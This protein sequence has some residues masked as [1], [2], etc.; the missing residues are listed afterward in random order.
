MTF[1]YLPVLSKMEELY[2]M[3]LS[4]HRFRAYLHLLQGASKDDMLMP[5]ASYNPMA[6]PHVLEKII[7]LQAMKAEQLMTAT[8]QEL[9]R[10][11]RHSKS[12]HTIKVA[13]NIADDIGGGWTNHYATDFDNKF[14]ING[15]V[16][17]N[18]CTPILWTSETYSEDLVVRRTREYAYRTLYWVKQAKRLVTLQDHLEQEIFV[19]QKM[20]IQ[21][22]ID[23]KGVQLL[24]RFYEQHTGASA[25]NLLFNFFYG[26]EAAQSLGYPSCGINSATGFDYAA[27]LAKQ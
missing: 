9:N 24:K 1:E 6:K 17:R 20:A 2:R 3:P 13:I 27:F 11:F 23:E 22:S 26:D 15:L 4:Q 12:D 14:K 18:F 8:L 21:P 16:S 25:Y 5:I 10:E 19:A 7:D